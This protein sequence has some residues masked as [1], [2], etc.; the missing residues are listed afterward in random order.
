[1]RPAHLL[2]AAIL[3]SCAVASQPAQ[4]AL[5]PPSALSDSGS[6]R[7]ARVAAAGDLIA[8][9]DESEALGTLWQA[10]RDP[11]RAS[12]V[13]EAI[14][15]HGS[16][17]RVLWTHVRAAAEQRE[18]ADPGVLA[19]AIGA[20]RSPESVRLLIQLGRTTSQPALRDA[21]KGKLA[22]LFNNPELAFNDAALA[23]W[24]DAR[25]AWSDDRWSDALASAQLERLRS[26]RSRADRAE[27]QLVEFARK[28]WVATPEEAREAALRDLLRSDVDALRS[29]A[30]ELI[31][32]MIAS[33]RAI[34]ESVQQEAIALLSHEQAAVRAEAATLVVQIAPQSA[35]P[36]VLD[37]L[38]RERDPR[39]AKPL[40][41]AIT[42]WPTP[43]AVEPV[44]SWLHRTGRTAVP[45]ADAA[46]ALQRAD[47]LAQP[48]SIER[49][50][51]A[52]RQL[53]SEHLNGSACSLLV[54]L[55]TDEDRAFV[56][57]LLGADRP[58]LRLAAAAALATRGDQAEALLG[59]A[60]SDPLLIEPAA[61]AVQTHLATPEG[62]RRLDRFHET[63]PQ[64]I[65]R[66]QLAISR[67]LSVGELLSLAERFNGDPCRRADALSVLT[68]RTLAEDA[69]PET[70]AELQR[71][72]A[73]LAHARFACDQPA[74]AIA[75]FSMIDPAA[76][77]PVDRHTLCRAYIR[78]GEFASAL[79]IGA[80][81]SVWLEELARLGAEEDG[82]RRVALASFI[83][84]NLGDAIPAETLS[85]LRKELASADGPD[86][87]QADPPA[88]DDPQD[89][90][91]PGL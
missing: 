25:R 63:S 22:E 8:R 83:V 60:E 18:P 43:E 57:S 28:A 46:L 34:P 74:Q 86:L 64:V 13:L 30:S 87:V 26:E 14:A 72:L 85:T 65:L 45:A 76:L 79:A 67:Q 5:D 36:A 17:P 32:E 81:P 20:F 48:E 61:R 69:A 54:G 27:R 24:L 90:D 31:R 35:G 68:E 15:R 33:G 6:P 82:E 52:L 2:S 38:I 59:A 12:I 70:R 78:T 42:R 56:A 49:V 66:A 19:D 40:L 62:V 88:S 11:Q 4:P 7:A 41:L 77:S 21:A 75:A 71:A 37:A 58:A 10:L 51:S 55:G 39:V 44:L 29:L 84:E 91:H 89:L 1:M 50:R 53:P 9:I 73:T 47:L 80:P 23:V 3:A 16:P